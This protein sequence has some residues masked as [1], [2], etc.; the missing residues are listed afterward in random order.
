MKVYQTK[1]IRNIALVGGTKSGKTTLAEAMLLEAG[2]INRR[3]SIDDKNTVSDYRDIEIDKQNSVTA[4]VLHAE[5][6]NHKINFIDTPGFADYIGEMIASLHATDA[7]LLLINAQSGIEV[8]TE[9]AWRRI[10][11]KHHPTA[12]VVNHLDHEKSSFEDTIARLKRLTGD[13]LAIVQYP[14]NPGLDFDSVIDVMEMK[15]FKYPKGGGKP[16]VLDIPAAQLSHAQE[17]RSNL[18]DAAAAGEEALMEKYFE[19]DTLEIHE[20]ERGLK[21]GMAAFS[22]FPVF[23]INAKYNMGVGRLM[24]LILNIVGSPAESKLRTTADGKEIPCDPSAPLSML[25]F[26]TTI[27]PHLG[28]VSFFR[29][30]SGEISE[31]MDVINA[32]NSGKE[33]IGQLILMQGKN[34]DKV[35]KVV[36]GDIAAAIKLKNTHTNHTL[37]SPKNPDQVIQKIEFPD[38]IY[39]VAIKAVNSSDDEK[40]G[41]IMNEMHRTDPTLLVGFSRELKQMILQ[42]QGELHINTVKWYLDH[43]HKIEIEMNVPKVPYRETITKPARAMYRHKKQTGGAGQFGEVHL[44]IQPYSEN[45]PKPTDFPV[46]DTEEH[47]MPWGGKLIFNICVVGGAIDARFMPAILKGI[48]ERMETGPLT[49]SY[50]R[51]ISVYIYDGKM[52]PVDSNE[53]SFRLAGRNS[54]SE[55]FRNAGPKIMEPVYDLDVTMP[56]EYMGDVMK[57]LQG[58]RGIIMGMDHEGDY[59]KI[60]AKVPLGE[61]GRYS[62]SLSAITSGR[63]FFNMKFSEYAQVP[64]EIQTKLLKEY[65]ESLKDEE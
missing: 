62:T 43:T 49:G 53:I 10:S 8:G 20:I 14:V 63:A 2:H 38:P 7:A 17:M 60:R 57:D 45:M 19:N 27:E 48:M 41:A 58:R 42:A 34:R 47:E 9:V 36:V 25:V 65:E 29:V 21:L 39:S 44:M 56:E 40:L 50:A 26:K 35:E 16:E 15:M 33:R 31:G 55:A 30:F 18:I 46:R 3:G 6:K 22:C 23:C 11:P 61:M 52:H 37:N 5:Y 59:Q 12:F 24:D 1:E 54:F 32:E 28:E 51:D 64:A 4:S 13:K